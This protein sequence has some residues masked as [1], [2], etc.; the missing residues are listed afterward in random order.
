MFCFFF[1]LLDYFWVFFVDFCCLGSETRLAIVELRAAII[2]EWE[3]G[4]NKRER[5]RERNALVEKVL[6]HVAL[7]ADV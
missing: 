6:L 5:E 3:M 7:M 2:K 4:K 1:C